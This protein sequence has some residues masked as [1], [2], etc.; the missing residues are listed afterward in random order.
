MKPCPKCGGENRESDA[1]CL[2]CGASLISGRA[3]EDIAL[4]KAH[5]P[6]QSMPGAASDLEQGL[7]AFNKGDLDT[8]I[9]ALK[10][11]ADEPGA[12]PKALVYL[13]AAHYQKGQYSGAVTAFTRAAELQPGVANIHY[14]LGLAAQGKGMFDKAREAYRKALEIDPGYKKASEALYRLEQADS[15]EPGEQIVYCANHPNEIAVGRCIGCAKMICKTCGEPVEAGK[16][17]FG[18]D[19]S[20]PLM[21]CYACASQDAAGE[22][23]PGHAAPRAQ[24]PPPAAQPVQPGA[25]APPTAA[26]ATPGAPAAGSPSQPAQ[27]F[28]EPKE[29]PKFGGYRAGQAEAMAA[30]RAYVEAEI[31]KARRRRTAIVTVVVLIVLI[32][33]PIVFFQASGGFAKGMTKLSSVLTFINRQK[34]SDDSFTYNPPWGWKKA[35]G[36]AKIFES[37]GVQANAYQQTFAPGYAGAEVLAFTPPSELLGGGI[38][39]SSKPASGKNL[40]AL[41][42]EIQ[43][44]TAALPVLLPGAAV[45]I[46]DTTHMQLPALDVYLELPTPVVHLKMRSIVMIANDKEHSI[47]LIGDKSSYDAFL[48][49]FETTLRTWQPKLSGLEKVEE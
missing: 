37:L 19:E 10:R 30:R 25:S 11:A 49:D 2:Y 39:V 21:K 45:E 48:A 31:A 27:R 14:N 18:D 36:P 12:D 20:V 3:T 23:V 43:Q 34:A 1:V 7:D 13:G 6:V 22:R 28:A 44:A 35:E 38:I 29:P 41:K 15:E 32:A 47:N 33:T 9:D 16:R 42:T 8:A 4:E 5:A 46:K 40:A 17:P 24:A 26:T